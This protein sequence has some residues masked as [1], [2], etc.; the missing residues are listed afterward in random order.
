[1]ESD[2]D[3]DVEDGMLWQ[4]CVDSLCVRVQSVCD[5]LNSPPRPSQQH[6]VVAFNVQ[7][8]YLS[9]LQDVPE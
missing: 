7:N 8:V 3:D 1:M 4:A 5:S 9:V 2:Y 6:Q